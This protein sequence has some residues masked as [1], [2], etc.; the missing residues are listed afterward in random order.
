MFSIW[1]SVSL[2]EARA[3][4]WLRRMSSEE[5]THW[6]WG[7]LVQ[8]SGKMPAC[9]FGTLQVSPIPSF[10]SRRSSAW[11]T[12]PHLTNSFLGPSSKGPLRQEPFLVPLAQHSLLSGLLWPS[13]ICLWRKPERGVS[14]I[15]FRLTQERAK[16]WNKTLK[17]EFQALAGRGL[18]LASAGL[19][20]WF[21]DGTGRRFTCTL[22]RIG[23]SG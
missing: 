16:H 8:T 21:L 18:E 14:E 20:L 10:P 3:S 15:T 12:L 1:P 2:S 17:V 5:P 7:N 9:F 13:V 4:Q 22:G 6:P 19:I 11:N 23:L